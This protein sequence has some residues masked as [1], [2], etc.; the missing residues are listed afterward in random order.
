MKAREFQLKRDDPS[1]KKTAQDD[2]D[3][4]RTGIMGYKGQVHYECAPCIDEWLG[5]LDTAIPRNRFFDMVA[6][7]IDQQIHARYR[8]YPCNY[9]AADMLAEQNALTDFY[10]D[11]DKQRFLGYLNAQIDKI[12]LC[13]KDVAFLQ[14]RML[15][16]YA[17]PCRNWL[18]AKG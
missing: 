8:L 4:M 14:E 10:T 12:E 1:W 15:T 13:H 2:V 5:S 18:S 3:S 6:A 7:H 17:N 11:E 16:M 9:I